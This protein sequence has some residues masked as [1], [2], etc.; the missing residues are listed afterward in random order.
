METKN[1]SQEEDEEEEYGRTH[2]RNKKANK[3]LEIFV[4]LRNYL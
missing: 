1:H 3:F 4:A 2:K